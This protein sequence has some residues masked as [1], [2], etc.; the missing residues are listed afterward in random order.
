VFGR[1]ALDALK[2]MADAFLSEDDEDQEA[3]EP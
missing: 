2:G 1:G 3:R